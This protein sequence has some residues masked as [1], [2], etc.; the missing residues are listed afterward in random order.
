MFEGMDRSKITLIMLLLTLTTA[1]QASLRQIEGHYRYGHEDNT[2]CLGEPERCYWLVDTSPEVRAELKQRVTGLKPYT[3]VCLRLIAETSA[4]KATGFGAD[5]DGSIRVQQVIG[6][7]VDSV[8]ASPVLLKDLAHRR[9]VLIRIDGQSLAEYA[10][11]LGLAA[12]TAPRKI[13]ELDFG[14]QGFVGGNNGCNQ[15]RGQARVEDGHL[16]LSQLASTRM[17][18]PGFSDALER[19]LSQLY[20]Q[21]LGITRDGETMLLDSGVTRLEFHRQDWK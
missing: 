17:A 12:E 4:E 10:A 15:I 13:P 9:W 3:P 14:E 20:S 21:K 7:C 5:Y 2:V 1:C 16:V 8:A 11:S 19:L 18:C 6:P